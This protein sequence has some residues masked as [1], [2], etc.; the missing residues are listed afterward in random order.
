M[1]RRLKLFTFCIVYYIL[2]TTSLTACAFSPS[3]HEQI[4]V[5]Q[6]GEITNE[7]ATEVQQAANAT[8][9][10]FEKNT[11]ILLE[12]PVTI[13]LTPN[14]KS[15]ITEL[16][17]RFHI[18]E[19]EAEKVAK[20]TDALSGTNLIVVNIDGIPT[21]R[22]KTFLI[23]HELTHQYQ[24]QIA[25]NRAS[26]VIWLLE[27]MSETVGAQVVAKQGYF[28]LDQYQSNWQ[29]GLQ[30]TASKPNLSELETRADW[31]RSLSQYSSPI[32]YKTAGLAVLTL[33]Q[34][35]G[36]QKILDYFKGLGRGLNPETAFQ[37]AFGMSMADYESQFMNT[38]RKAS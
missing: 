29:N 20:G 27:G 23:A 35:F 2:V 4:T 36:E 32:T 8:T 25:G 3:T 24:R 13:V 30:M 16:I 22:Q 37:N 38:L 6:I 12:K 34:Q 17:T 1:N 19:L 31:S 10:L 18:S 9:L 33:T 21:V 7:S 26:Q 14:R 28:R 11:G 15:Y 5:E